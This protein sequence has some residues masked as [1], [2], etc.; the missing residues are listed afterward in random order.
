[1]SKGKCYQGS[2]NVSKLIDMLE[3]GDSSFVKLGNG[4]VHFNFKQW[5][6]EEPDNYNNLINIKSDP[7]NKDNKPFFAGNCKNYNA[8]KLK[9]ISIDNKELINK[10][11]EGVNKISF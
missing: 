6:N 9:P 7:L 11:K 10:A 2:I 3:L 1:M 4:E 5:V 8:N